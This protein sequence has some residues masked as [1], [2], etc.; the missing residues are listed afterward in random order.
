MAGHEPRRRSVEASRTR[1]RR[2]CRRAALGV[3]AGIVARY[4]VAIGKRPSGSNTS[5]RAPTQRHSPGG[6]GSS[7]TRHVGERQR[8]VRV[9]RHHRLRERHGQVRRERDVSFGHAAQHR[10]RAGCAGVG[11]R[12]VARRRRKR[13]ALACGPCAA[14]AATTR[15]ART[16]PRAAR[17]RAEAAARARA[18]SRPATVAPRAAAPRAQAQL[19]DRRPRSAGSRRAPRRS[20]P[21]PMRDGRTPALAISGAGACA[22]RGARLAAPTSAAPASRTTPA[23]LSNRDITRLHHPRRYR[24]GSR[25]HSAP[26]ISC[27]SVRLGRRADGRRR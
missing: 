12:G 14:A 18:R 5:V 13:R 10:E 22:A 4:R 23:A 8:R 3:P 1:L 16:V 25:F 19:R 7:R 21:A 9:E 27:L 15:A 24:H 11:P 6:C 2:A 26:A 17:T 20:G